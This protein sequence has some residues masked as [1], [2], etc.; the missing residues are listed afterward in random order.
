MQRKF[1]FFEAA[2]AHFVFA[3]PNGEHTNGMESPLAFG[4]VVSVSNFVIAVTA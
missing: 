4:A 1:I 3:I 2:D